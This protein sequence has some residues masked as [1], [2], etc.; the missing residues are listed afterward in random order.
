MVG[1]AEGCP[2]EA[3]GPVAYIYAAASKTYVPVPEFRIYYDRIL[4]SFNFA[5][6]VWHFQLTPSLT[7]LSVCR[8]DIIN[9]YA[10]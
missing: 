8:S 5:H 6:P 9:T 1:M 10:L 7:H 3:A 4:L 2:S